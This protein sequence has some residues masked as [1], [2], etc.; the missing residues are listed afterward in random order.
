MSIA[1]KLLQGVQ[2]DRI[3]DDIRDSI[4]DEGVQRNHLITKQ[5]IRNINRQYNIEGIER[6]TN[7]HTSVCSWIKS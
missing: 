1:G 4:T 2:V 6:H 7:D 5:D 3:L